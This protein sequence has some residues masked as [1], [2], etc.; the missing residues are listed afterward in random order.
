MTFIYHFSKDD[1]PRGL[2]LEILLNSMCI[3]CLKVIGESHFLKSK[4]KICIYICYKYNKR[5][6]FYKNTFQKMTFIYH[7]SKDNAPRGF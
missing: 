1:A 4:S 3:I 5:K 2:D 6:Y 7:V